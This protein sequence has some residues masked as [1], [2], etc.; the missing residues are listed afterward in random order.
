MRMGLGLGLNQQQG[1]GV[2]LGAAVQAILAGT[3]GFALDPSDASTMHQDS[4]RTVAVT[5]AA[6]P[7]GNIRSKW[8]TTTYD[9]AQGTAGFRPAWN[10]VA[11]ITF[12]GADDRLS[13]SSTGM[14]QNVPGAYCHF[15]AD[16]G[17]L[18]STFFEISGVLLT[19]TRLKLAT[20]GTGAISIVSARD[21]ATA[22]KT[23]S[24]TGGVATT[25]VG[26]YAIRSDFAGEN[27]IRAY[28]DDT[29][30]GNTSLNGVVGNTENNPAAIMTLGC[31]AA[32]S[33]FYNGQLGRFVV[34]PFAPS[35]GQRADIE[36]WVNAVAL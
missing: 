23:G 4:A 14:V 8:G 21:D 36:A 6:D 15:R 17:A 18:N 20:L 32:I 24:T 10:G 1:G 3:T 19:S 16:I 35:A 11:G 9:F 30:V 5:T 12:D 29:D 25:G 34:C 26:T 31:A 27:R 22:N 13:I 28:K 2:D 33:A 7:I